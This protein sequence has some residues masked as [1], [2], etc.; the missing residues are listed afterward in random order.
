MDMTNLSYAI[1]VF[2]G[3]YGGLTA[4][5]RLLASSL[6]RFTYAVQMHLITTRCD[7]NVSFRNLSVVS[8]RAGIHTLI[9]RIK[10]WNI[11]E[12][13]THRAEQDVRQQRIATR[14]FLVV[15][16]GS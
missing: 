2:I 3:L 16:A 9:S 4:I 14:C 12:S 13:S 6:V 15:F 7:R 1:T 10:R 11:F 5:L 8:C